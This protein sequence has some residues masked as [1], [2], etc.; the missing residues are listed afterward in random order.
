[1]PKN[2][3]A[4]G[5]E[6]FSSAYWTRLERP[7]VPASEAG[8][9]HL[10]ELYLR[11]LRRATGTLVRPNLCDGR[12]SL[13]FVGLFDLISFGRAVPATAVANVECRFPIV[14]GALVACSGGSLTVAQ[15]GGEQPELG[16]VVE[17]YAPRLATSR[18]VRRVLYDNVQAR[19]HL[20]ISNRF[21]DHTR[22]RGG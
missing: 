20:A 6:R 11:E 18:W 5:G 13:T 14:G 17:R 2:R 1:M 10:G 22:E 3:S 19:L 12:V 21:L 4:R 8:A 7:V 9:L 16:L 15:R